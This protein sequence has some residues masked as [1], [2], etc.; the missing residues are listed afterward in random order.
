MG[1]VAGAA[2]GLELLSVRV[3]LVVDGVPGVVV[4]IDGVDRCIGALSR[5][6]IDNL[7]LACGVRVWLAC[8]KPTAKRSG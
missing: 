8:V 3:Q 6:L 5:Q 2:A 4:G 7:I 1:C